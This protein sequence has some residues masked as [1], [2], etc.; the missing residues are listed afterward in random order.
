ML[1]YAVGIDISK[2][3]VCLG[4]I[5]QQSLKWWQVHRFNQHIS[6]ISVL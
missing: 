1:K 2:S 6:R 5:D 4:A 3:D